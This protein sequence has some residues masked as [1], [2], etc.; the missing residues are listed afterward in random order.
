MK[1]FFYLAIATVAT[2]ASCSSDENIAAPEVAAEAAGDAV[3]FGVYTQTSRSAIE[4][5]GTVKKNGFG[6]FAFSQMTEDIASYTKQNYM[7]DFMYN[8]NVKYNESQS[9]WEYAPIKYWPN[10]PG[11]KLSFYAYAPYFEQF[12]NDVYVYTPES[13]DY[14]NE[15]SIVKDKNVRLILGYDAMGPAIEYTRS[16]VATEGVDLLWGADKK[17]V[18]AAT[19]PLIAPVN[20]EKQKV[21]EKIEFTFKHAMSR[22]Y[23]NV[24]VFSD[25]SGIVAVPD[26]T[27]ATNP[28]EKD[29]KI[30]IQKVELIGN[31]ANKG[32]LRLYDGTWKIEKGDYSNLVFE[33]GM[34]HFSKAV[35]DS[36][37]LA[38]AQKE[39]DLLVG[40]SLD[41][42][43][44]LPEDEID[45]FVMVMPGASFYIQI[46]YDVITTDPNNPKNSSKVT[47]VIKSTDTNVAFNPNDGFAGGEAGKYKLEAGK[48]YNFHLNIGMTTVKFDAEV[49]DWKSLDQEIAL[50]ENN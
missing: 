10:N 38:D 27:P 8:Q 23:F 45:N 35:E 33:K 44:V 20:Y 21:D 47:N 11:A 17:L 48:A 40:K 24:Q 32:T 18:T 15:D 50:P 25:Q 37:E 19:T 4:N 41:N 39:I 5:Y 13:N 34:G 16:S 42:G 22:L 12:N 31:F 29:T 3:S 1:K 36:L 9:V 30:V 26:G 7:P 49:E 6:V 14:S 2:L 28:L 46:T 43:T